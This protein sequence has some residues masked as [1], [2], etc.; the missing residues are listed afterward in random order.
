MRE[1][2]ELYPITGNVK[3][4]SDIFKHIKNIHIDYQ[5]ENFILIC[6]NTKNKI[7]HSEIVFKGGLNS[8]SIDIR[9]LFRVALK[10][11]SC[12][13]IIA[14]NHPSSELLPSDEDFNIFEK[15][16]NA[17]EILGMHCLDSI[18]FNEKEFHAMREEG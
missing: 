5:Q 4:S 16:K 14:H 1:I 7:I 6:L 2:V 13:I 8:C 10:Y 3:T 12:N 15:I 9:T 18:V 11:N 17:G